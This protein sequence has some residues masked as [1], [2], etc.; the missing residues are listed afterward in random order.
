M[1]SWTSCRQI[2]RRWWPHDWENLD[3]GTAVQADDTGTT[4][5]VAVTGAAEYIRSRVLVEF[6]EAY[7]SWEL[8]RVDNRYRGQAE[9]VRDVPIQH[10]D[11]RN[12]G[13]LEE[14]LSGAD[15]V[16]HLVGISGVDDCEE[17]ADLL[18]G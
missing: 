17:N 16:Y 6:R 7:L 11:I 18:T 10:V 1:I 8:I 15:V 12:R 5:T 9:S 14:T 4:P 2:T 3:D 13:R